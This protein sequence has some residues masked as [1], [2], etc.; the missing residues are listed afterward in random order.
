MMLIAF[1]KHAIKLRKA[2]ERMTKQ[3]EQKR[4]PAFDGL[5]ATPRRARIAA[6]KAREAQQLEHEHTVLLKLAH[7]HENGGVPEA[8]A[9]VTER[10]HV[11]YMLQV[12][13]WLERDKQDARTYRNES[14]L[15]PACHYFTATAQTVLGRVGIGDEA[16]FE[17]ALEALTYLLETDFQTSQKTQQIADLERSLLGRKLPSFFP[18][19]EPLLS[20]LV[21]LA[22]VR[23]GQRVLEP[24]AGS[25]N[26]VEKVRT[27]CPDVH[28]AV[29]ELQS[30]L[31]EL[32]VLKGFN[33][34]GHDFFEH[35]ETYDRII[36]NPP[37][38]KLQD[39]DHIQHAYALLAPGGRFV[40]VI[41]EAPFFR[42]DKKAQKFRA[43]LEGMNYYVEKNPPDAFK[44]SGTG[45]QTRTLVIDKP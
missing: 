14:Y 23:A 25:G 32:L 20:R 3:L 28:L 1:P 26:I 9:F 5:R 37:F 33:V 8:L 21:E 43:W 11:V 6:A 10:K 24:S 17:R 44:L 12:L 2:A 36:M 29:I 30:V 39:I 35:C 41:S 38:E 7:G 42:T 19:P 40:S 34:V 31:C 15:K 13:A 16:S 45:V 18:T 27:A 22:A 4:R